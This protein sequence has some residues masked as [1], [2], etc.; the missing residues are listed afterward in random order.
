MSPF[1]IL[2]YLSFYSNLLNVLKIVIYLKRESSKRLIIKLI[3]NPHYAID[4]IT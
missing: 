3:T 4:E 2:L 1:P